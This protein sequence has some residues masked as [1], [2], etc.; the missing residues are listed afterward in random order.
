ME[1]KGSDVT[2]PRFRAKSTSFHNQKTLNKFKEKYPKYKDLTIKEFKNIISEFNRTMR[3]SVVDS[4][5]GI[6]LPENLGYVLITKTIVEKGTRNIDYNLSSKYKKV[7]NHANW[8]SDN[9]LAKISYTNYR[10]KYVFRSRGIWG[11]TPSSTFKKS[12]SGTFA[13]NYNRYIE[14]GNKI[15]LSEIYK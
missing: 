2:A 13:E 10:M 3:E 11:F 6:K 14:L 8:D 5:D 12:V 1:Y 4:R 7:V 9:Y 15:K